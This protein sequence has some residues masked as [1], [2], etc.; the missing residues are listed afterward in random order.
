MQRGEQGLALGW[1]WG[2][3][4]LAQLPAG[5]VHRLLQPGM[6]PVPFSGTDRGH[7]RPLFAALLCPCPEHGSPPSLVCG[8]LG[9]RSPNCR[10][11]QR[12][13]SLTTRLS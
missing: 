5:G 1:G 7:H 10:Q 8:V 9:L 2:W 6:G 4:G 3:P 12:T 11:P 13:P